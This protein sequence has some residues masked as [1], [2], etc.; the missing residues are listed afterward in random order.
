MTSHEQ[1]L[2]DIDAGT[3]TSV[4]RSILLDD[5]ARVMAWTH[6]PFGHSLDGVYGTSP[7][8]YRFSGTA[9]AA[10]HERAWTCVLKIVTAQETPLD[11]ASPSVSRNVI[12]VQLSRSVARHAPPPILATPPPVPA[13]RPGER[14][15]A[16]GPSKHQIWM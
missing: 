15:A 16:D 8:I 12:G 5:T 3:L 10:G 13:Q 1:A 14:F 9:E 2:Q 11:P 7:S 6:E 4:V